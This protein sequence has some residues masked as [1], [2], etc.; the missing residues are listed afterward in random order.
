M[1]RG[2]TTTLI[3]VAVAMLGIQAMAMAPTIQDVPSPIVGNQSV[4]YPNTFVFP[5][6][7]NLASYVTDDTTSSANVKWSYEIVGTAHYNING[8]PPID[9]STEDVTLPG[10]KQI[11][12]QVL[13][14]EIDDDANAAS[15]T[16]RNVFLSPLT[17]TGA[18]P[19]TDDAEHVIPGETQPVTLWASDGSAASSTTL[20]F[21][22][23]NGGQSRF[24]P[25]APIGPTHV[26]TWDFE[27]SADNFVYYTFGGTTSGT[28][29]NSSIC[30]TV[31]LT[32][33]NYGGW[34]GRFGDVPLVQNAVY[35]VRAKVNGLANTAGSTPFWDMYVDSY[36]GT[37]GTNQYGADM[38]FFDNEG[39]ANAALNVAGGG[40]SFHLWWA[41]L[42]LTTA[43]WNNATSG[44]FSTENAASNLNSSRF[45]FR[46]LDIASKV[47]LHA[48]QAQ[49]TLCMT[50][51][52]VERYDIS[53]MVVDQADVYSVTTF[54]A[55]N[56]GG[57]GT[58][59]IQPLVSSPTVSF[60]GGHIALTADTAGRT[61]ELI[62]IDCGSDLLYDLNTPTTIAD[63]YPVPWTADTLYQITVDLK[64]PEA[65]SET[66]PWDVILFGMDSPSNEVVMSSY[67]TASHVGGQPPAGR[68]IVC[69]MPKQGTAQTY[70]AFFWTHAET[71]KTTAQFHF[72]RP[73]MQLI[74][75]SSLTVGN[76]SG[77]LE[78]DKF[79][80][81]KVHFANPTQ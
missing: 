68:D 6:A 57:T 1:K 60:A 45:N 8:V 41:P 40:K 22:S 2:L 29:S 52:V 69:G 20:F 76:N 24:S 36:D 5:D 10:A 50:D 14:S 17:G 49:G 56:A 62:N 67:Q 72:L 58:T 79:A 25:E 30:L 27:G 73:R 63:N 38:M 4:T 37:T 55:A 7:F 39:G 19:G 31:G 26:T 15:L 53:Q 18:T 42:P 71:V 65:N 80:V 9:S 35:H 81:N 51:T 16:I 33:D 43:A 61:L 66:N 12:N 44:I 54:S 78:I 13:N 59:I 74:N 64:A 48:D 77:T 70:M 34:A 32:G 23:D 46:V 3:A 21:Y 11:N 28:S 47:G 75:H